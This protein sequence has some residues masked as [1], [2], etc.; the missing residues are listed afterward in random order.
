[1]LAFNDRGAQRCFGRHRSTE[2][3]DN[4]IQNQS[5]QY[6][7]W[8]EA[9]FAKSETFIIIQFVIYFFT[10]EPCTTFTQECWFV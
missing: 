10:R 1:M 4:R 5:V 3:G 7:Y 8:S 6:T 2:H 9:A